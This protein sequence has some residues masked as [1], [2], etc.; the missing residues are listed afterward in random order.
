[1]LWHAKKTQYIE[2]IAKT[3]FMVSVISYLTFWGADLVQPGFVSRYFSVHIFLLSG[4]VF[5]LIWGRFIE[6]YQDRALIQLAIAAAF[7]VLLAMLTWHA[8]G[9]LG[10]YRVL[11]ALIGLCAPVLIFRLLK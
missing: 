3:G 8:S 9:D 7:G 4:I 2:H 5:G 1:M 11:V 10:T 6:E